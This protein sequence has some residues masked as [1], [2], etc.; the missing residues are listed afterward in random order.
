[1]AAPE[2]AKRLNA[3]LE[4]GTDHVAIQLLGSR[5]ML[6]STLTEVMTPGVTPRG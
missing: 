5:D 3:F 1:M 4:V 6:P 2:V